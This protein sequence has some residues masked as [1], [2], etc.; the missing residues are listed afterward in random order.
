MFL[1]YIFVA[2]GILTDDQSGEKRRT[3]IVEKLD[4][5]NNVWIRLPDMRV[6]RESP[7]VFFTGEKLFVIGG[8]L[9]EAGEG[10]T[11]ETFN[12]ELNVWEDLKSRVRHADDEY[13]ARLIQ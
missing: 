2:G 7:G 1:G 9:D 8:R 3:K 4:I 5:A 12:F 11:I 13:N 6:A 10:G